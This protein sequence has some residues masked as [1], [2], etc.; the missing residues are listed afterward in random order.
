[1]S[2]LGKDWERLNAYVDGEL[3]P[4]EAAAVA[5]DIAQN[6]GTAKTTATLSSLKSALLEQTEVPRDFKLL[7]PAAARKKPAFWQ[8]AHTAAAAAV[9]VVCMAAGSLWHWDAV[10]DENAQLPMASWHQQ[11][12]HIH[13]DWVAKRTNE[14]PPALNIPATAALTAPEIRIPDLSDSGLTPIL[15]EAEAHLGN[16]TGYRVG[17]GGTQG[18]RISFFVLQGDGEI[19]AHLT[20]RKD[21]GPQA[22]AWRHDQA[23][24][25]LLAE[26][27]AEARFDLIARTLRNV[28]ADWRPLSP[29]I[30]TA[31]QQNRQKSAPCIT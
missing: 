26:G 1:M 27:M 23:H 17:Y 3:T 4:N 16:M 30:R 6:P 29:E 24:Y 5:R 25:L 20:A 11:A 2:R 12:A 19:P 18:C 14:R 13:Q 9:L 22:L 21:G 31:L 8:A 15:L 7:P 10:R 28:T